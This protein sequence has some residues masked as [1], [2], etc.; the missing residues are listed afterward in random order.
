LANQ[1]PSTE[2]DDA[3]ENRE[4]EERCRIATM[5]SL[6]AAREVQMPA[7]TFEEE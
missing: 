7:P 5:A 4:R 3:A 6:F 2:S 1:S